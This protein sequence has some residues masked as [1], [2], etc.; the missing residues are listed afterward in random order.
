V[1]PYGWIRV[2]AGGSLTLD[3]ATLLVAGGENAILVEPGGALYVYAGRIAPPSPERGGFFFNVLSGAT[4]VMK[5]S[6]LTGVGGWPGCGDWAAVSIWTS[7][8][9]VENNVITDCMCG[10]AFQGTGHR[11]SGNSISRTTTAIGIGNSPGGISGTEVVRN[12]ISRS[13]GYG[14]WG[15]TGG[16]TISGNTVSD[17]WSLGIAVNS[18]GGDYVGGNEI[19]RA[20]SGISVENLPG[21]AG[22]TVMWNVVRDVS[23]WG[24]GALGSGH[25]IVGNTFRDNGGGVV[26]CSERSAVYYNNFIDN[27]IQAED[28][29][30][31]RQWDNGMIGNFWSDYGGTDPDHDGIGETPYLIPSGGNGGRDSF[32]LMSPVAGRPRAPRLK[33][34][35]SS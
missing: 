8:A 3:H 24:L 10:L 28:C 9:V 32:P 34:F 35:P 14:I 19:L 15:S 17:V 25:L 30:G 20:G 6:F 33:L 23:G 7:N 29:G 12:R 2:R 1:G 16:S 18:G 4:L 26:D 13:L 27:R 22:S 11:V 21:R 31:A 5:D